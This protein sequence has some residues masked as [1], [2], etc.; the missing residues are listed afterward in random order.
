MIIFLNFNAP[1]LS[2]GVIT[3]WHCIYILFKSVKCYNIVLIIHN[4]LFTNK[5]LQKWTN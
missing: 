4:T 3:L 5:R 2:T 1:Y